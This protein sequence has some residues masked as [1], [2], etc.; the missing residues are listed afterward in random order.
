MARTLSRLPSR[1]VHILV[2]FILPILVIVSPVLGLLYIH[3]EQRI[4]LG[5]FHVVYMLEGGV[6]TLSLTLVLFATISRRWLYILFAGW[7]IGNLR[8]TA[9]SMGWDMQWLGQNIP[10]DSLMLVRKLTCAIYY[11]L[12]FALFVRLFNDSLARLRQP[13]LLRLGMLPGLVLLLSVPFLS[14]PE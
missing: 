12:T 11:L 9:L 8:I 4:G 13:W 7:L 3:D 5:S 10:A 6:L 1:T 2:F 14:Y